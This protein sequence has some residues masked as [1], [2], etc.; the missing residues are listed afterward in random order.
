V[1]ER[2][3]SLAASVYGREVDEP[4]L[5]E[6]VRSGLV[7][8][9]H[10]GSVL[11]LA[12][13]GSTAL[14]IGE[15]SR[16]V[17]GRSANKPLQATAM[18]ELGL[19]LEP[20][21]LALVC[22]SHNGE[23]RHVAGVR[24]ILASAGLDES[25]LANTPDLPLHVPSAHDVIRA[26]GHRAPVL[27]NCSGKHA[28]ML[29]VCVLNGWPVASYVE[30]DHPLQRHITG[31]IERMSGE[32]VTHIGVDGCGA[33]AHTLT[34][35]GLA[36]AFASVGRAGGDEPAATVGAAMRAHPDMVG[37]TGR[38]ITALLAGV[39][40]LVAKDGA[41]GVLAAAMPDGRAV[42]LKL[43]DGSWRGFAAVML[44]ALDRLGVATDGAVALREVPVLGGGQPVG[45]AHAVGLA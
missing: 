39:P 24:R 27:Q 17:Y 33:P 8:S 40:G 38:D 7:E 42:A 31:V 37:G 23:P 9:R 5:V 19:D 26:G 12:A 14:A 44:A 34:L 28:G 10:R 4:V 11:G 21:L 25:V 2:N 13:D 30:P 35:T 36:R 6:V 29:A 41:E 43:A 16:P 22:A 18:V 45:E 3:V 15:V 1:H 20:E 32:N